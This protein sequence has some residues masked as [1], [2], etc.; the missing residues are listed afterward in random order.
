M[1][2]APDDKPITEGERAMV[3][4]LAAVFRSY[5]EG[6][7]APHDLGDDHPLTRDVVHWARINRL[8]YRREYVA[9]AKRRQRERR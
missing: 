8:I 9:D 2:L 4:T 7:P 6:L 5:S 1:T 3:F